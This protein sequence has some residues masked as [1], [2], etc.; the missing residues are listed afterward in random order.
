M[1]TTQQRIAKIPQNSHSALGLYCANIAAISNDFTPCCVTA[2]IVSLLSC[3]SDKTP[4]TSWLVT[5]IS[6]THISGIIVWPEWLTPLSFFNS[7]KIVK[8]ASYEFPFM[9]KY[10]YFL[11]VTKDTPGPI[12]SGRSQILFWQDPTQIKSW[13]CTMYD[14]CAASSRFH[15]IYLGLSK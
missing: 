2:A 10:V 15:S 7:S 6:S 13:S 1:N 3:Q 14:D 4:M 5:D 12:K 8:L 9:E 11:L